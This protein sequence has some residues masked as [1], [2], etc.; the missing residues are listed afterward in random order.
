MSNPPPDRTPL[1]D[2]VE[3][4]VPSEP[5][6]VGPSTERLPSDGGPPGYA[7]EVVQVDDDDS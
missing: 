2:D 1:P 5:I 6:A 4:S 7:T 3:L